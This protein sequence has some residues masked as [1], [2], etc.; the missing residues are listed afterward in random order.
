MIFISIDVSYKQQ[1][2]HFEVTGTRIDK[3]P[4]NGMTNCVIAL[5]TN[6]A[7]LSATQSIIPTHIAAIL[8]L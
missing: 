6:K 2:N 5:R 7:S 4:E 8:F 1:P 3:C